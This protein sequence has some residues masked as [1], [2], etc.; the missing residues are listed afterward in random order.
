MRE[1][2]KEE[3]LRED[4]EGDAGRGRAWSGGGSGGGQGGR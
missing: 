3:S 1:G 2:V 4:R